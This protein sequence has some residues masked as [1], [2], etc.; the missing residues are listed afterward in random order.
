M[1]PNVP[2]FPM[3]YYGALAIGASVVPVHSLLVA[4]EIDYVLRDS[5][6]TVFICAGP[7]LGEGAKGAELAGVPVWSVLHEG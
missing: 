6:A 2:Q 5:G 4:D 3:A 1:I 7:L